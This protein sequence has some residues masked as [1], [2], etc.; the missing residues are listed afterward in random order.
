MR[1][2]RHGQGPVSFIASPIRI[3][4]KVLG[5]LTIEKKFNAPEFLEDAV[6]TLELLTSILA[7]KVRNFQEQQER[8]AQLITENLELRKALNE[9][10]PSGNI[11]GK[12][13]KIMKV[14]E[15][16]SLTANTLASVLITGETGT[17]KELIARA[18]HN[19]S[20]RKSGPFVGVNCSAVPENLLEAELFGY[21]KGAFTGAAANRRGKFEI[22]HTGTLFLD[23]I[24]DMP[25][26]LQAKILRS[27][28]EKEIQPL[29]SEKTVKVDIRIIAATNK[30]LHKMV[31]EKIFRSD[32]YFRLNVINIH[33][34]PLRERKD[35]IVLLTDFFIK[36]Y[37]RLYNK[38]VQGL[39]KSSQNIFMNYGWPGNI[40]ELENA[41]ERAIILCQGDMIDVSLLPGPLRSVSAETT[42]L[43][44]SGIRKWI[45]SRLQS[46]QG[47]DL[48]EKVIGD[49]EKITV[50]ELLVM[51][52]YN[53]S[54]TAQKLGINRNTLKDII[55]K[56]QII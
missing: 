49:M 22:A 14:I 30:D 6:S 42:D 33:L 47:D 4:Q 27:L 1:I 11:I 24:G 10:R 21:V 17:G 18:L 35:D 39:D 16:V 7:Q 50:E 54:R 37:N 31:D 32:L 23:E 15:Q 3:E 36:R 28:E 43:Q 29:G 46:L 40:R 51:N 34:P 20:D 48:Y 8:T 2:Q 9:E 19:L 25:L 38:K 53:K 44:I 41:I 55:R 26:H 56:R 13:Q 52:D 12:D 45:H 5:V